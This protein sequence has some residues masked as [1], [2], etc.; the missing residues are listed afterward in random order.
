MS[1]TLRWQENRPSWIFFFTLVSQRA[2]HSHLKNLKHYLCLS[3][4]PCLCLRWLLIDWLTDSNAAFFAQ[5]YLFLL[6]WVSVPCSRNSSSATSLDYLKEHQARLLY[7][8]SF[9][10]SASTHCSFKI[11]SNYG[12]TS[13]LRYSCELFLM[14]KRL[15]YASYRQNW[16]A[17]YS[18]CFL[19]AHWACFAYSLA[20]WA[21]ESFVSCPEQ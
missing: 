8:A 7:L 21:R 1:K 14:I 5:F 9:V 4:L 19:P 11:S 6:T 16:D 2:S 20:A 12:L 18:A 13:Y 17:K 3:L 15:S 10:S